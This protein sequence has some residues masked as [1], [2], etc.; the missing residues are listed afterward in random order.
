MA[1]SETESSMYAHEYV[2]LLILDL[3]IRHFSPDFKFLFLERF[4]F[5]VWETK[6]I[7]YGPSHLGSMGFEVS[8]IE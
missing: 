2:G 1:P 3:Q 7:S 8:F 5:V 4:D 6:E